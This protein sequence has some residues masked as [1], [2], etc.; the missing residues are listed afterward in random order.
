MDRQTDWLARSECHALGKLP[1][2]AAEGHA[3]MADV[4]LARQRA[5][6]ALG[7]IAAALASDPRCYAAKV[8]EG[9]AYDFALDA[10]K[11]EAAYR[12]A[13][14]L[15][16]DGADA[17][18]GLGRLLVKN[19]R[20]EEGLAFLRKAL[21]FEGAG[22][23]ALY[24]VGVALPPGAESVAHL[25]KATRERP[26]FGEAWIALGSE[27]LALRHMA[28]ARKAADAALHEVPAS[29][30]AHVLAG[31]VALAEGRAD[32]AVREGEAALR[33][34]G[35]S[36]PA[37]LLVADG[38]AKKG[39]IDAAL[40]AYQA[41]WG[42]DH[43]DPTPLVHAAEACHAAG[44]NTSAR[45]YGLKATQEFPRWGPAWAALGDALAA[46]GEA[47]SAREAYRKALAAGGLDDR[48]SVQRK[49]LAL[50]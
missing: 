27:Q 19:G 16:S 34:L 50:P 33:V 26:N 10:G 9:R 39:D 29:A 21:D 42:L 20:R 1:G 7:E 45:A 46:N 44:R 4:H 38:S 43:A 18:L 6:E 3:C 49:L 22:P 25:E 36:A 32:E 14:A 23:E 41:A 47:P 24:E 31:R 37:R 35:N 28:E 40:E 15:R 11:S 17:Y 2:S 13:I 8:A 5:T 12:A 30:A 48:D